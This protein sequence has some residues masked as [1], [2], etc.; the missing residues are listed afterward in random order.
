MARLIVMYKTPRDAVAFDRHYFDK[1]VPLAKT[2]PGCGNTKSTK[3]RSERPL[4]HQT[5]T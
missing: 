4:G 2:I 5:F 1:H 3:V